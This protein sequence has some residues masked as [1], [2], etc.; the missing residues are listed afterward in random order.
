MVGEDEPT[1]SQKCWAHWKEPHL[2]K[3]R[4]GKTAQVKKKKNHIRLAGLNKVSS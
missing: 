2:V 1:T 4:G 3:E